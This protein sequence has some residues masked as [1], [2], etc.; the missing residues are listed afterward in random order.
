MVYYYAMPS[1]VCINHVGLTH[2]LR[3]KTLA[4]KNV[5]RYNRFLPILLFCCCCAA[6]ILLAGQVIRYE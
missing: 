3:N 2:L 1:K 6:I 5:Q 4:L